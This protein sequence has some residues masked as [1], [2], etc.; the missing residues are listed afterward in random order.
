MIMKR[1]ILLIFAICLLLAGCGEQP[2]METVA[3]ELVFSE[4]PSAKG[5][6]PGGVVIGR[7]YDRL[8]KKCP[9]TQ[10]PVTELKVPGVTEIPGYQIICSFTKE[11]L[12]EQTRFTVCPQGTVVV[13]SRESGDTIRLPGGTKSLKK[14]FIDRKI[15]QGM[16][17]QIP[18]LADDA[19]VVGVCGIGPD[20]DRVQPGVMIEL[21]EK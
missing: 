4:N 7:N 3:D 5:N 11:K 14:L 20:Q 1:G 2:V 17:S 12:A 18:V 8:E 9:E 6:F 15:P 10:I 19:G 21:R 13:R 16:R